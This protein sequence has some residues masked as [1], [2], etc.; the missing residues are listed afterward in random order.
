MKFEI[1]RQQHPLS[2]PFAISRGTKRF[3]EVVVVRITD[4]EGNTGIGE[5]V[6]YPRYNESAESA[7]ESFHQ[8]VRR[9]GDGLN[10]DQLR[11]NFPAGSIRNAVD[12]ALWHLQA[13]QAE[14]SV[15]EI[16]HLPSPEPVLGVCSLS[17]D[18]P[19][20]LAQAALARKNFP[21]LKIKLGNQWVVESIEQ[22]RKHCPNHRIIV[23]ANE[24]WSI[25]AFVDYLPQLVAMGVEMIEQPLPA[26]EDDALRDIDSEIPLCA[27]ESF[28]LG[29]DFQHLSDRYDVFNV[30]LDKTGGLTE[31]IDIV[32]QIIENGKQLMIGSMMST[33]YS[34]A[35]AM[36]LARKASYVDLDSP[37]WLSKDHPGGIRF[38]DGYLYPA[39]SSFWG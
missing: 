7:T 37:V 12:C 18:E 19:E 35:P 27:D 8:M 3:V 38:E 31:A 21:L 39:E 36:L 5:C 34:L 26:S 15:H 30:K 9:F 25:H 14:T 20:K 29:S 16:A 11:K 32:S 1:S 13:Q 6:P 2:K 24:A 28:H 33:S 4:D 22:I 23:D 17:L 10:R